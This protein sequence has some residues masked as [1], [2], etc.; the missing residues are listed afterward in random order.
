[1]QTG[2]AP[3]VA[4]DVCEVQSLLVL[5]ASCGCACLCLCA[6]AW[7]EQLPPS[8]RFS[9]QSFAPAMAVRVQSPRSSA[10]PSEPDQQ[11]DASLVLSVSDSSVYVNS[12]PCSE[13]EFSYRK[14]PKR[15]LL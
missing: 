10:I 3:L 9:P 6:S 5:C 7:L 14:E 4:V 15:T 2:R 11:D 8:S 12:E 13:N 1:M